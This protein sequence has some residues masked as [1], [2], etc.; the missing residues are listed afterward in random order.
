MNSAHA[1]Q[2]FGLLAINLYLR[3]LLKCAYTYDTYWSNRI[4]YS[5][6]KGCITEGEEES[7]VHT[8]NYKVSNICW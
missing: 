8:F 3:H 5:Q 2:I 4:G 6:K 7:D 1:L